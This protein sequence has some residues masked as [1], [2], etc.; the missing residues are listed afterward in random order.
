M[1]SL[2]LTILFI[3]VIHQIRISKPKCKQRKF[4]VLKGLVFS[5]LHLVS[6]SSHSFRFWR[7]IAWI[8]QDSFNI[9]QLYG[10]GSYTLQVF[11]LIS[12][13][14]R[15]YTI[16]PI[17]LI[18]GVLYYCKI[19]DKMCQIN[20]CVFAVRLAKWTSNL[21]PTYARREAFLSTKLRPQ[22]QSR[23]IGTPTSFYCL[24]SI[25]PY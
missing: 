5:P 16:S 18:L 13:L 10:L 12:S 7:T 17:E 22:Q 4:H 3:K 23:E 21:R 24:F 1:Y 8:L 14:I 20:H 19:Q 25:V 9:S 15:L 6:E 11:N 2:P